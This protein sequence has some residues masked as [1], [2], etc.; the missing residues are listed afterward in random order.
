MTLAHRN[1]HTQQTLKQHNSGEVNS[2]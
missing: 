1:S 2:V